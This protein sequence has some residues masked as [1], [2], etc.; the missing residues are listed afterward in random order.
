MHNS[1]ALV[2]GAWLLVCA[3]SA[4]VAANGPT[5]VA[6]APAAQDAAAETA[7]INA[8]FDGKYEEQL[9]LSPMTRAYAGEKKDYDKIDDMSEAAGDRALEWQRKSVEELK[10]KFDRTKLQPDAQLSYDLWIYQIVTPGQA[11]GYKIGMIKME[12][13][14]RRAEDQLGNRFDIRAFHDTILGRA[15]M[16]LDLLDQ[17]VNRWIAEQEAR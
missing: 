12:E 1:T 9:D 11:T 15:Q 4:A 10:A 14:R 8:W 7:R 3:G 13:L 16:P 17:R 6:V 5:T 2:I